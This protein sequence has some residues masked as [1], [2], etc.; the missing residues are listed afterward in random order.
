[1]QCHE[2]EFAMEQLHQP[3]LHLGDARLLAGRF[4]LVEAWSG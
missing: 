3:D 1:M 2:H 4:Q